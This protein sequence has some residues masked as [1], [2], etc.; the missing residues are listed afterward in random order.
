MVP[1]PAIV[2]TAALSLD[3]QVSLWC[4]STEF[5]GYVPRRA[6]LYSSSLFS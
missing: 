1:F 5:L 3:A 6:E 4:V 2:T